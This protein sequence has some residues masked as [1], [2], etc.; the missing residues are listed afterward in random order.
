MNDGFAAH[1]APAVLAT[2]DRTH[3]R[4]YSRFAAQL[5][6]TFSQYESFR[7]HFHVAQ[8]TGEGDAG[9][10]VVEVE[11]EA[12]PLSEVSPPVRKGDQLHFEF[13]HTPQ[14]WKITAMRPWNFFS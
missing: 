9:S 2:F 1:S 6:S 3:M 5:Q 13:A 8:I 11:F 4:D 7:L 14:G 10:A 12:T